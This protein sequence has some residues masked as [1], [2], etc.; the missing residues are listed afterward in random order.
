MEIPVSFRNFVI[1]NKAFLV[2]SLTW[3][4]TITTNDVTKHDQQ[5]KY[6]DFIYL[7]IGGFLLYA[8]DTERKFL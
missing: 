7:A 2:E 1:N 8:G 4:D 6:D 5:Q 3:M